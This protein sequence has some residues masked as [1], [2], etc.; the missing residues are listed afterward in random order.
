MHNYN[1]SIIAYKVDDQEGDELSFSITDNYSLPRRA[2]RKKAVELC[3]EGYVTFGVMSINTY[4]V[5][6][7][8]Q[9][10]V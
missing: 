2:I 7:Q 8:P 9:G 3:G 6:Y 5:G 1:V 4:F 10:E